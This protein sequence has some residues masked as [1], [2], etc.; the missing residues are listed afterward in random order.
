MEMILREQ[1]S[2]IA[3]LFFGIIG[4][5]VWI[6][7]RD[8]R[9]IESRFGRDNVIAMSFG[10]NYFGRDSDPGKPR[11]SSGFLILLKDR[12]FYRSRLAGLEME[13][14]GQSITRIYPD[15]AHKGVDLH[16]SLLKIEFTLGNGATDSVAFRVPYP[17]QWISAIENIRPSETSIVPN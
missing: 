12:L 4:Y 13:I 17:P 1:W 10:V 3:I 16:Q 5:V 9:W 15:S 6:R 2:L 11:R 7:W 14:P 8:N